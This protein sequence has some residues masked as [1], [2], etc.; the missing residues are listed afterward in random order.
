M[1][2]VNKCDSCFTSIFED[3]VVLLQTSEELCNI[4]K[5]AFCNDTCRQKA[6]V[7]CPSI[8]NFT[9]KSQKC[10]GSP[11]QSDISLC[12][13]LHYNF[14]NFFSDSNGIKD[15][16]TVINEF[17]QIQNKKSHNKLENEYLQFVKLNKL[18]QI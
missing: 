10:T 8:N 13:N 2:P 16:P 18:I 11:T 7:Y 9:F 17:I 14:P 6:C 4:F 1:H 12:N 3:D 15:V 5:L